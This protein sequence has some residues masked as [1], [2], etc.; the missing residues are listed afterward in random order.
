[1][2]AHPTSDN[3][4]L[5]LF[6]VGFQGNRS[7]SSAWILNNPDYHEYLRRL[8][9]YQSL[10]N[11][12]GEGMAEV[13]R[14]T[15]I[16]Q[17]NA[18]R[19]TVHTMHFHPANFEMWTNT[20]SF[21]SSEIAHA[22]AVMS[23]MSL[24]TDMEANLESALRPRTDT[25]TAERSFNNASAQIERL[26][27]NTTETDHAGFR[28]AASFAQSIAS[29]TNEYLVQNFDSPFTQ[30]GSTSMSLSQELNWIWTQINSLGLSEETAQ[31]VMFIVMAS[32]AVEIDAGRLGQINSR[33]RIHSSNSR[34]FTHWFGDIGG[35]ISDPPFRRGSNISR[36]SNW[37]EAVSERLQFSFGDTASPISR[38]GTFQG[39][40]NDSR[41]NGS[42]LN[43][44]LYWAVRDQ[45]AG[46]VH[47]FL[48]PVS[49]IEIHLDT[50]FV[51]YHLVMGSNGNFTVNGS[52][53][54][55]LPRNHTATTTDGRDARARFFTYATQS[56]LSDRSSYE[57]L[58]TARNRRWVR[59]GE[60]S[61]RDDNQAM[62]GTLWFNRELSNAG[63]NQALSS[64]FR[65]GM[66]VADM[67]EDSIVGMYRDVR[68]E[69]QRVIQDNELFQHFN[70][71]LGG[72]PVLAW[73]NY[74][75]RVA[76]LHFS[77]IRLGFAPGHNG[78]NV[79]FTYPLFASGYPMALS[80][81]ATVEHINSSE[82]VDFF[83]TGVNAHIVFWGHDI[84]EQRNIFVG[85]TGTHLTN[86]NRVDRLAQFRGREPIHIS[87]YWLPTHQ[88]GSNRF[89]TLKWAEVSASQGTHI[90]HLP[91]WQAMFGVNPP[92]NPPLN[93]S[94]E[95]WNNQE[96]QAHQRQSAFDYDLVAL[97]GYSP[98]SEADTLN[99]GGNETTENGDE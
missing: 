82:S 98:T 16:L 50:V 66:S 71:E 33:M 56:A 60:V 55:Y 87:G 68:R 38:F 92:V 44:H 24:L 81:G 62:S 59:F 20:E 54:E 31:R 17:Q 73:S 93:W 8:E 19:V 79:L 9:Y 77:Q 89:N 70:L 4:N 85:Q 96:N 18:E 11:D 27:N 97:I 74:Q 58:T 69:I 48:V 42:R 88:A 86:S 63:R 14:L 90:N 91:L 13:T 40:H 53:M 94:H 57:S 64:N 36:Y 83:A 75:E 15:A 7:G 6:N 67:F 95:W 2:T 22:Q 49:M 5:M 30:N 35:A 37:A 41:Q 26:F 84:V 3:Q 39:L 47:S 12:R 28:A 72:N 34:T 99:L 45:R 61:P 21:E 46:D 76:S 43:Q 25:A 29:Q 65:A 80:F 51:L 52:R 23:L 78:G 1:M 10:E 32:T